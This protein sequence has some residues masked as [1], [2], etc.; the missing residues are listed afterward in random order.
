MWGRPS[1]S[2]PRAHHFTVGKTGSE[3]WSNRPEVELPLKPSFSAP[4][5]GAGAQGL[6]GTE[7]TQKLGLPRILEPATH[8]CR[9]LSACSRE[10]EMPRARKLC[11]ISETS[12]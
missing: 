9:I 1:S 11:W 8:L 2:V 5:A 6:Q 4:G 12:M 10:M 3:R 7:K